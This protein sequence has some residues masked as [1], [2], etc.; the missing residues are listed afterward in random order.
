MN[1]IVVKKDEDKTVNFSLRIGGAIKGRLTDGEGNNISSATIH[2]K[3]TKLNYNRKIEKELNTTTG[4]DGLFVFISIPV[5]EYEMVVGYL[6]NFYKPGNIN[7]SP[8]EII[9]KTFSINCNN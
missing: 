1:N 8:N 2:L 9:K 5:G 6:G 7:L 3:P 4:D